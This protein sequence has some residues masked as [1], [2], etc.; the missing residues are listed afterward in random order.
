MWNL[1]SGNPKREWFRQCELA[2]YVKGPNVVE[3]TFSWIPERIAKTGH[4]CELIIYEDI[5]D[6]WQIV[7]VGSE[8]LRGAEVN[9][10]L[11]LN[12]PEYWEYYMD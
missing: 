4:I 5:R 2:R 3:Y 11:D 7:E 10:A 1:D 9:G 6:K 8:R 12:V